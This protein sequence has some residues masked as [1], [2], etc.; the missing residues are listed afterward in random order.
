MYKRQGL[1]WWLYAWEVDGQ[2]GIQHHW[3]ARDDKRIT[4]LIAQADA[5]I[6]WRAAGAPEIDD[7]PDN[8]DDA[9]ADYARGLALE[10][11]GKRLKAAARSAI[12]EFAAAQTSAPGDPLRRNGSRAQLFFEPKPDTLTLDEDA[13]AAAEPGTYAEWVAA[14]AAAAAQEAAALALYTR[15]K[16]TAPTFRVT[17][18]GGAA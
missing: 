17:A 1:D 8:V 10:A 2:P 18:N 13:W 12:D 14:R 9:L 4:Q 5:F 3:I 7:I 6:E 16:P 15:A 11:E